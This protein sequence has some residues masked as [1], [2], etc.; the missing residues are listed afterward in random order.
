MAPRRKR[1]LTSGLRQSAPGRNDPALAALYYQFGRYLIVAG[2]REGSSPLN[3]QGI[4][5]SEFMPMWDSKYTVNINLQM[6]YWL[7]E[8]GNLSEQ[9]MPVM[10]LI[11]KMQKNGRET[12]RVMYGM[13]GMVCHHN[14]DYYG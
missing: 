4:W 6:N 8:T 11:E 3:L 2:G 13:R 12:A 5:N 1:R 7:V 14:T 10:D 9:H